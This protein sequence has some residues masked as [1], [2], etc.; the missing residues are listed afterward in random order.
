MCFE[1]SKE[2]SHMFWLRN[3]KINFNY[4]LLSGCLNSYLPNRSMYLV[5][6][7][8]IG[9]KFMWWCLHISWHMS[10]GM[11]FP[12]MWY[13]RPAKPQIS[14]IRAFACHLNILWLLSYWPN[15]IW[16]FQAWKEAAQARLSLHLSKCHNV[17][18]H[19]SRLIYVSVDKAAIRS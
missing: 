8:Y 2:P 15:T 18:N 17:G 5:H 13:V 14:L 12:T 16:S 6:K 4:T 10:C 7:L 11:R 3:K 19:M 9:L 1:C